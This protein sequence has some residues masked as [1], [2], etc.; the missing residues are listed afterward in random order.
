MLPG[1]QVSSS[2]LSLDLSRDPLTLVSDPCDATRVLSHAG[3]VALE[4]N[5]HVSGSELIT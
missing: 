2:A 4:L 3:R 1:F 5:L